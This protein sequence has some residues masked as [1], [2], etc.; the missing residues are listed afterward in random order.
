[1]PCAKPTIGKFERVE[2]WAHKQAAH[3]RVGFAM[4]VVG[5][6]DE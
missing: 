2:L 1:M 4:K 5:V 3:Y 6:V